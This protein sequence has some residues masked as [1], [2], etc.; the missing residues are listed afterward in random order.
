MWSRFHWAKIL[1]HTIMHIAVVAGVGLH[2]EGLAML[3][4]RA[5]DDSVGC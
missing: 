4:A 2:V 5:H 1:S 3:M